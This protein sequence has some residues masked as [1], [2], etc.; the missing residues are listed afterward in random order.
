MCSSRGE[1]V[2]VPEMK[3]SVPASSLRMV[4]GFYLHAHFMYFMLSRKGALRQLLHG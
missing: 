1:W 2:N 3:V 4:S